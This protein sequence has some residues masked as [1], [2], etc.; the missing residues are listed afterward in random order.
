MSTATTQQDDD[1]LIIADDESSDS[2]DTIEF[3]FDDDDSAADTL[4]ESS[5][6]ET[7]KIEETEISSDI[8]LNLSQEDIKDESD[9][10][11]ENTLDTTETETT[12]S[13]GEEFTLDFGDEVTETTEE[14]V[15]VETEASISD[16][17]SLSLEDDSSTTSGD[18]TSGNDGSMNDILSAT[19][20]KLEA[21]KVLIAWEKEAKLTHE[22]EIKDQIKALQDEHAVIEAELTILDS[23]S[24][25]ITANIS[26]LENMKLDPVKDHN[27]KRAKK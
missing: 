16:L 7:Q 4:T 3:S 18:D 26:K 23:E 21:R 8:K 2:N 14:S 24:S 22:L 15:A 17:G 11:Q 10:S 1:L 9:L 19:I 25:N 12:S 5:E 6:V 27:S 20:A 13:A